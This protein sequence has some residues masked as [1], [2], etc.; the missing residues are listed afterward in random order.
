MRQSC[1]C[2]WR[3]A[4]RPGDGIFFAEGET[5]ALPSRQNDCCPLPFPLQLQ[6]ES[7]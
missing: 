7:P 2:G 6:K 3:K 5:W 4:A 1:G